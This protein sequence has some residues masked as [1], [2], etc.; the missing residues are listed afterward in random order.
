MTKANYSILQDKNIGKEI[1]IKLM[2][3]KVIS[4]L[5]KGFNNYEVHLE[6]KDKIYTVN[7]GAIIYSYIV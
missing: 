6:I 1:K 2:T 5:L 3:D 7:K 4:G